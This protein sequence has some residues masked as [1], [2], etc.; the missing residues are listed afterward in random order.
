[1]SVFWTIEAHNGLKK[2]R[3]PQEAKR[4]KNLFQ[5][6]QIFEKVPHFAVK[7]ICQCHQLA[8]LDVHAVGFDLG[9]TAL[10]DWETH[11]IHAGNYL[12]LC[13]L[14]LIAHLLDAA[15]NAHVH[16]DFLY[17]NYPH[18]LIF[19]NKETSMY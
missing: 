19:R 5:F 1:M 13:E 9:I 7:D 17:H 12:L 14:I 2:K 18:I 3:K 4:V 8:Y 16:S 6:N 15:A 11:Q 10:G